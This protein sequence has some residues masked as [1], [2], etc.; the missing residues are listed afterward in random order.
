MSDEKLIL[1]DENNR[2]TG[3]GGKAAIHRAG[4]LHDLR[5]R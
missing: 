5:R 4:L 1:V 3:S 2:A